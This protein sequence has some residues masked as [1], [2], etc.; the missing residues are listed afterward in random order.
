[1]PRA[2]HGLVAG[3]VGALLAAADQFEIE[4]EGQGGHASMPHDA[5]DPVPPACEIVG[6]LQSMVTRRFNAADAVVVTVSQIAAGTAHNIIADRVVLKGT[7]RTLS[8][9]NRDMVQA[10]VHRT[11]T[12]IAEAHGVTAKVT[13]TPGF[14]V[15]LCD[16]RAVALGRKVTG[17]LFGE[18]SWEEL[19]SPIMGAEDFAYVLEKVPGA[20]FFL[21][22]A[23]EGADWTQCCNIHS[24]RMMVDETALPH[25]VAL[26]AGC[27]EEFLAH[28]FG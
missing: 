24:P 17:A 16:A 20:M 9:E 11:A 22:V 15:T 12:G 6:A 13:I 2:R 25:G 1:M 10:L 5:V 14:P 3:R 8:P 28:G 19:A 18:E 21:G 4:V 27:A 7:L 26:L 23:Q